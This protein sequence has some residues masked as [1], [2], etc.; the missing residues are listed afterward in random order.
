MDHFFEDD[1]FQ[2]PEADGDA[3]SE[4]SESYLGFSALQAYLESTASD[5]VGP[6]QDQDQHQSVDMAA[7]LPTYIAPTPAAPAV[8]AEPTQPVPPATTRAIARARPSRTTA[9][10]PTAV[11]GKMRKKDIISELKYDYFV[12]SWALEGKRIQRSMLG[13]PVLAHRRLVDKKKFVEGHEPMSMEDLQKLLRRCRQGAKQ[14]ASL[15]TLYDILVALQLFT[16]QQWELFTRECE[17]AV[18]PRRRKTLVLLDPQGS[19]QAG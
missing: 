8:M 11:I 14:D 10:L 2:A 18:I 13:D 5:P 1:F 15:V 4:H 12:P 7:G 3:M 17:A 19:G 9:V 16:H 6:D